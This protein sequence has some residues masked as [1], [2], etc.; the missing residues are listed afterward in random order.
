MIGGYLVDVMP[1]LPITPTFHCSPAPIHGKTAQW[2]FHSFWITHPAEYM[3]RQLCLF[4]IN[5]SFELKM[6][7]TK[8]GLMQYQRNYYFFQRIIGAFI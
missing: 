5:Y 4:K 1:L 6:M 3:C 7:T 2:L 8:V